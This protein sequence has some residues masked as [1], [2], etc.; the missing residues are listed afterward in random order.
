MVAPNGKFSRLVGKCAGLL[1]PA[2]IHLD[3]QRPLQMGDRRLESGRDALDR[4]VVLMD[5]RVQE[6]VAVETT[7][8]AHQIGQ[9]SLALLAGFARADD[10]VR[11][12]QAVVA[13]E[14]PEE[15]ARFGRKAL[16]RR[17]VEHLLQ[18]LSAAG[19]QRGIGFERQHANAQRIEYLGGE[20]QVAPHQG[21]VALGEELLPRQMNPHGRRFFDRADGDSTDLAT[22]RFSAQ[23]FRLCGESAAEGGCLLTSSAA[24]SL[25]TIAG[26]PRGPQRSITWLS[27]G[28][29]MRLPVIA[30]R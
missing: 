5:R 13:F 22:G 9:H 4:S 25:P 7:Q 21:G 11:L 19:M 26:D 10:E 1:Q 28:M 8:V 12:R 27:S 30:P 23:P 17:A 29:R 3:A 20:E 14:D 6:M 16:A 18:L 2:P 15:G 24:S